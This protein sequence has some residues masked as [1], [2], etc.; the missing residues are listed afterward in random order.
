M[1]VEKGRPSEAAARLRAPSDVVSQRLGDAGV[2]IDMR[3]G[4]MFEL[5]ATGIRV[6]ELV[7]E[8]CSTAEAASRLEQEFAATPAALHAEVAG[9]VDAL[10]REGLLSVEPCG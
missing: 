3:S 5:N 9:L 10:V 8:G 7:T 4:R 6:W 2:L 1:Q